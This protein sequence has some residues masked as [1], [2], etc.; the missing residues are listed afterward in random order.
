MGEKQDKSF[1]QSSFRKDLA[2]IMPGYDWIVHRPLAKV[3]T[4]LE[5]TGTKSSGFNRLSTLSVTRRDRGNG[6]VE[7]EVKSAGFGTRAPWLHTHCDVTLASALRGLQR[8]YEMKAALYQ[9]HAS[10]LQSARL[11]P[12]PSDQEQGQ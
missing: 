9:G 5:A 3:A 12:T 1:D 6:L 4:Y 2:K 8:H 11:A 10:A 7:Y